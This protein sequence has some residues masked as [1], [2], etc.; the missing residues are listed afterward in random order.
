MPRVYISPESTTTDDALQR[1]LD[2]TRARLHRAPRP[3]RRGARRRAGK[4]KGDGKAAIILRLAETDPSTLVMAYLA[5][6]D[7]Q[8]VRVAAPRLRVVHDLGRP[9]RLLPANLSNGSNGRCRRNRSPLVRLGGGGGARLHLLLRAA[10]AS[11]CSCA[12][13]GSVGGRG[14]CGSA[15]KCSAVTDGRSPAPLAHYGGIG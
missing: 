11:C 4:R 13:Y 10:C 12:V 8:A 6:A 9:A 2:A 7:A 3:T 1:E 15:G 5:F 14:E